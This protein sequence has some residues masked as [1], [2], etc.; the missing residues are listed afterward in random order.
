MKKNG[1]LSFSLKNEREDKLGDGSLVLWI[2]I[3]ADGLEHDGE[4]MHESDH[5]FDLCRSNASTIDSTICPA[6]RLLAGPVGEDPLA[7]SP[8]R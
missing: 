8:L 7:K 1:G 4:G 5:H 3:P 2:L 6:V